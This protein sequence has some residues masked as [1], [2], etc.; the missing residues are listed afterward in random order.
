[1]IMNRIIAHILGPAVAALFA[2]SAQAHDGP[3]S[4]DMLATVMSATQDG[5]R[6]AVS[7]VLTGLGGPLVLTGMSTAGATV[8]DMAPVY[9]N[10]A[11][12][13]AVSN[14]LEFSGT[15]PGIFTLSLD[16]GP[17]GQGA[18]VVIPEPG[19]L[20]KPFAFKE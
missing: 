9:V 14:V 11:Q 7:L 17:L 19:V 8:S 6:I 13:V 2:L 3:H 18:V 12:D 5:N 10:F 15:P 4:P 1:M 20:P 16:F